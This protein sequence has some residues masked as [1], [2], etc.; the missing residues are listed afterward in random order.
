MSHAT[1]VQDRLPHAVFLRRLAEASSATSVEARLGQ[2]ALLALRLM[3]LLA[4]PQ[5][6]HSGAFHYQS[7]AT[8]R[9]CRTLPP[10]GTEAAHVVGL[11]RSA[12]DAFQGNDVRLVVPALL[13]YAHYLEDELRLDAGADVLETILRVAGDRIASPDAIAVRLRTARVLR[14]LNR[15]EAADEFY[16]EA[17]ALAGAA[18]DRH[19]ELVSRL[20]GAYTLIGRGNLPDAERRLREV[21]PDAERCGDQRAQALAHQGLGVVLSTGGRPAEA[22]PH[23]WRAFELYDDESSR[24][25]VLHDLGVMLLIVGD[26]EGAERALTEVVR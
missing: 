19:S 2:G 10:D 9:F 25:R 24:M 4:E 17:G 22:I 13:A 21:L 7:A 15:F 20:G 14:K 11:A 6:V 18:G 3:D 12:A 1:A 8:E 5:S 16:A 26:A 23:T